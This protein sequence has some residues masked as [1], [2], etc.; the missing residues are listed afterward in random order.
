[1]YFR[2]NWWYIFP[3]EHVTC[4]VFATSWVLDVSIA[5]VA[6]VVVALFITIIIF[7]FPII[8]DRY[9]T[10]IFIICGIK[11]VIII[12]NITVADYIIW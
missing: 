2:C 4:Y 11:F 6:V 8:F 10:I 1:M 3:H 9:I 12:I 5:L 7:I